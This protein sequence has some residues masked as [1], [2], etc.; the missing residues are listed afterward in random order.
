[1]TASASNPRHGG[2]GDVMRWNGSTC[3]KDRTRVYGVNE[4]SLAGA[5]HDG[6]GEPP[7][8]RGAVSIGLLDMNVMLAL[9]DPRHVHI[10]R[11]AKPGA[12]TP[13]T[14]RLIHP[15]RWGKFKHDSINRG[16][17]EMRWN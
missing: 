6:A 8:G 11:P 3:F 17:M 14:P 4:Q 15:V 13:A 2:N 10:S 7:A 9:F 16:A 1:M 12:K 5:G